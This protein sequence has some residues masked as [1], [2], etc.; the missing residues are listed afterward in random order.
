M[1]YEIEKLMQ[2]NKELKKDLDTIK[3]PDAS[4]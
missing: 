2:E 3:I 4:Y 1:S